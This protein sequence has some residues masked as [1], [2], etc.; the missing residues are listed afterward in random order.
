MHE[1]FPTKSN[2][3]FNVLALIS[4]SNSYEACVANKILLIPLAKEAHITLFPAGNEKSF[5]FSSSKDISL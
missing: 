3:P 5:M 2:G 1:G 4:N